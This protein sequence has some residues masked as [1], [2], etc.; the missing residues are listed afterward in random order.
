MKYK[1]GRREDDGG[2]EGVWSISID[3]IQPQYT[4]WES[5]LEAIRRREKEANGKGYWHCNDVLYLYGKHVLM[6]E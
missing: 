3:D 1:E 2:Q 5:T 6:D 4:K